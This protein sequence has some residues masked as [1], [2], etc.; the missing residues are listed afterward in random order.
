MK[1]GGSV[2]AVVV[3]S[4]PNGLAAAIELGRAGLEVLVLEAEPT[5]GGGC[6]TA[7]LTLPGFRHD[8]C[9][10]IHALALA[11]PFM[12]SLRLEDRGVEWIHPD[13]PLAHPQEDGTAAVLERDVAGT[14]EGLGEDGPAYERLMGP[15]V[16]DGLAVVDEFLAPAHIPRHPFAMARFGLLALRS[17]AGLAADRFRGSRPGPCSPAW[18][19]TRCSRSIGRR[20]PPSG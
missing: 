10:A 14:A 19:P 1:D 20:R 3:G 16:R 7:E 11:S 18:P 4:G 17:A 8:V 12:R 2:D 5:V 9:S 6:R 13:A 15:L